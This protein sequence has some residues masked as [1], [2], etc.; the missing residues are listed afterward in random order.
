MYVRSFLL[1]IVLK[2]GVA[3]EKVK[4]CENQRFGNFLEGIHSDFPFLDFCRSGD[5]RK[6]CCGGCVAPLWW[7]TVR[8]I[9]LSFTLLRRCFFWVG[10]RSLCVPELIGCVKVAIISISCAFLLPRWPGRRSRAIILLHV[11]VFKI[12]PSGKACRSCRQQLVGLDDSLVQ[13]PFERGSCET[14]VVD[15][16]PPVAWPVRKGQARP[17][18]KLRIVILVVCGLEKKYC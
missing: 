9:L 13:C 8:A 16:K 4:T 10:I 14:F 15:V 1:L 7:L 11:C 5:I 6:A 17:L 2:C 12:L 3:T 18:R